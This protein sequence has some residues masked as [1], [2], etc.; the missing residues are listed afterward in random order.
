MMIA[1]VLGLFLMAG[2]ATS[3]PS[4]T[5]DLCAIFHDEPDWYEAVLKS[6]QRWDAPM[7]VQMA[8]IRHESAFVSDAL[9]PRTWFLFI[10]TG[11]VS[12]AYGYSQALDGTWE[13]YLRATGRWSASRD[14]FEDATDFVG[15]YM[16]QSS[17]ELGINPDD[18]Y[19]H[20]L[21][22]H[23]GAGG[24]SRGSYRQ[25]PWLMNVAQNVAKTARRYDGQLTRCRG[26][27]DDDY[28]N[29]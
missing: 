11:R 26:D 23:E 7:A 6:E 17:R 19:R 20:Y 12:T 15:W 21:A 3:P 25:K 14:D 29:E 24:Y 1:G 13:R 27:F 5:T 18:A 10:P 8:I 2:C 22:Y 9:P 4:N 28:G 16:Q